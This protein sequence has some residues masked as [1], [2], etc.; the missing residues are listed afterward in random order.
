[1]AFIRKN[2]GGVSHVNQIWIKKLNV[3]YFNKKTDFILCSIWNKWLYLYKWLPAWLLTV[4][5]IL[6]GLSFHK[7]PKDENLKQQWLIKIKR[8]NIQSIQ[9]AWMCHAYCFGLNPGW[10]P[11]TERRLK[12]RQRIKIN[13]TILSTFPTSVSYKKFTISEL[14]SK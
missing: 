6:E 5:V 7:F 11:L 12:H 2:K 10:K 3:Y 4:K 13:Q 1:M 14:K 9:D 8:R